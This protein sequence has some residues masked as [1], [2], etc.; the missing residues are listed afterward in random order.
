MPRSK[1]WRAVARLPNGVFTYTSASSASCL[2]KGRVVGLFSAVEGRKFSDRKDLA[3]SAAA[4][5]LLAGAPKQVFGRN[6]H[7]GAEQGRAERLRRARGHSIGHALA[8]R[9]AQVAQTRLVLAP[10][11]PPQVLE[12]R[13]RLLKRCRSPPTPSLSGKLK[14]T[15]AR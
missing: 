1:R 5:G 11:S 15:G 10:F 13:Q 2:A 8:V 9:T 14:S 3:A 6:F 7:V 12:G 4:D